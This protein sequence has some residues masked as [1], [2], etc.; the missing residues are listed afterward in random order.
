MLRALLDVI[1]PSRGPAISIRFGQGTGDLFPLSE[2]LPSDHASGPVTE[3]A[4]VFDGDQTDLPDQNKIRAPTLKLPGDG[5]PDDL[6]VELVTKQPAEFAAAFGFHK[7][8]AE[9]LLDALAGKEPHDWTDEVARRSKL[10]KD[11]VLQRL[12]S[13]VVATTP[14]FVDEFRETL[15]SSGLAAFAG[16][17]KTPEGGASSHAG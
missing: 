7:L 3:F 9:Q 5:D 6:F 2:H 17:R 8:V 15:A 12:A 4:L 16:L 13:I 14:Q 11:G 10:P 1:D